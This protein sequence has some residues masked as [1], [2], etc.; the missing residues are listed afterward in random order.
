MGLARFIGRFTSFARAYKFLPLTDII[1]EHNVHIPGTTSLD[2]IL[3]RTSNWSS[4]PSMIL[5]LF[6]FR[7][8]MVLLMAPS[9]GRGGGGGCTALWL[10]D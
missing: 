3:A 8:T 7:R 2:V 4:A 9:E 10:K 6:R 5:F 1:I